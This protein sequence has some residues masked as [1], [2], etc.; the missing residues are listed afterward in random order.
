MR[1]TSSNGRGSA[2]SSPGL[3]IAAA[4]ARSDDSAEPAHDGDLVRADDGDA[5][6]EI[7]QNHHDNPQRQA[8]DERGGEADEWLQDATPHALFA[9]APDGLGRHGFWLFRSDSGSASVRSTSV[10]LSPTILLR[11]SSPRVKRYSS[12]SSRCAS[13]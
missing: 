13:A 7:E 9:A 11:L 2:K 12:G 5:R 8:R 4:G 3:W 6:A 1:T 10:V